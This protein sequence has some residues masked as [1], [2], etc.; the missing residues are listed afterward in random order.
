MSGTTVSRNKYEYVVIT[1]S[2]LVVI[3]MLK[4]AY[5]LGKSWNPINRA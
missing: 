3:E 5:R 2:E 4:K 1:P